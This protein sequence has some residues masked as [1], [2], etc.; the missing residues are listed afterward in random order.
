MRPCLPIQRREFFCVVGIL[1]E[2]FN[3]VIHSIH[4]LLQKSR[5]VF[6]MGCL[7]I[8]PCRVFQSK[9]CGAPIRMPSS[10]LQVQSQA[11]PGGFSVFRIVLQMHVKIRFY[12]QPVKDPDRS[13]RVLLL[14]FTNLLLQFGFQYFT[15]ADGG[16]NPY[17]FH[18][19]HILLPPLL[20]EILPAPD[21]Q[22]EGA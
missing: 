15:I 8:N 17:H 16:T 14:H 9:C 20:T 10:R 22:D 1:R 3:F 21:L 12:G 5:P 13:R 7:N 19:F 18:P 11:A 6:F 4:L 2:V